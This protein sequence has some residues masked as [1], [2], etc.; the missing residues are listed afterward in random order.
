M[1][2]PE[3]NPES[4][5]L[6]KKRRP[7]KLPVWLTDEE[8]GR[9]LAAAP[10]RRDGLIIALGVYAGLRVSEIVK[11]RIERVSLER[12]ELVVYQGKGGKDRV[13]PLHPALAAL[14]QDWI[15]GQ[16]DGWLFPS[17]VKPEKHL[18]TRAVQYMA[19]RAADAAGIRKPDASLSPHKWRHSF[20]TNCLRKGANL[21]QVQQL[22]GHSSVAIT[23]RYTHV[24]ADELRGAVDRL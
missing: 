17:P 8:C 23:E 7:R 21:R 11:L 22:L 9:L 15:A 12:R 2:E 1:S 24:M 16:R 14:L 18:T 6:A 10:S 4:T 5:P 20:A 3:P 13:L 19:L